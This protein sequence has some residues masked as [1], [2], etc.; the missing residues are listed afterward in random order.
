MRYLV[1]GEFIDPGP[2]LPP[3]E[4]VGI[5]ENLVIPSLKAMADLEKKRKILAGGICAGRRAGV[6]IIEAKSHEDLSEMLRSLPFWGLIK[7]EVTP[8]EGF[9]HR[10]RGD[11]ERMRELKASLK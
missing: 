5:V 1:S 11:R 9:A 3:K 6:M 7:W 8:L 2:L 4:L 10:A